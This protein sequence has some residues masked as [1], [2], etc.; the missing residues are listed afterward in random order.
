MRIHFALTRQ[1]NSV[2]H[3][4]QLTNQ[5]VIAHAAEIHGNARDFR[6]VENSVIVAQRKPSDIERPMMETA[7][8]NAVEKIV[9]T[10]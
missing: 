3:V 8:S 9:S 10:K 6:R 1:P 7:Q 2:V 4:A 5:L